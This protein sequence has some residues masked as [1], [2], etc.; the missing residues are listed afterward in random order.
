VSRLA[1]RPMVD[2]AQAARRL[3][4]KPGKWLPVGDYGSSQSAARMAWAIRSA[5][6]KGTVSPYAPAGAFET[7]TQLTE[8]GARLHA[9]YIGT[10]ESST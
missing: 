4:A 5:R 6:T 10:T 9:R 1:R 7:R 2:H 8:D 3:R